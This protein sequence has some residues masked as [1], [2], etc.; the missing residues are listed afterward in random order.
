MTEFTRDGSDPPIRFRASR[1]Q[2]GQAAA[3]SAIRPRS[4]P[5]PKPGSSRDQK[6]QRSSAPAG[7]QLGLPGQSEAQP[8][9][10]NHLV[11]ALNHANIQG[12]GRD[13]PFGLWALHNGLLG[14]IG[15]EGI[16]PYDWLEH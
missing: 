16:E 4:A 7:G 3:M 13:V 12:L 15:G 5:G 9:N 11:P 6:G 10:N 14:E 8:G 2:S 1:G